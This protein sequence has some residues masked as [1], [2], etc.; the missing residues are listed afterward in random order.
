MPNKVKTALQE[1]RLTFGSWIQ[2]AHPSVAEVMAKAGF[3]WLTFDAEHAGIDI[4]TCTALMQAMSPFDCVPMVRIPENDTLWI[5]RVLDAGGGGVIV[6]MVN[7]AEQA[8]RAVAAA[9]YPPEGVRGFGFCRANAY[10]ADF[11]EYTARA[12][13]DTIVVA[14]VEHIESVE[15]IDAILEVEG[16]DGIFIGPYDLSG[17][18]N[19]PGQLDDPR[20]KD[21]LDRVL[22][23]CRSH[24]KSA[25]L[26]VVPPSAEAVRDAIDQGF[27]FLALSVDTIML[28]AQCDALVAAAREA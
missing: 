2:M 17:S 10:G 25:G 21:A 18:M 13:A 7:T 28:K 3:E 9:K 24:G 6:P 4:E 1:C 12:N 14:Q 20:V 8:E 22:A 26:H 23:A 27:T 5:R 16:L 11:E 19:I 15:N